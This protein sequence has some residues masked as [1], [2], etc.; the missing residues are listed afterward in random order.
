M[1]L[2]YLDYWY[3]VLVVPAMLISIYAQFKVKST[4]AKYNKIRNVR[5]LTGAA[6]ADMVLKACGIYDVSIVPIQGKLTDNYNPKNKVL[7]LSKD[8]FYGDTIAAVGVACHEAGHAVQHATDYSP[9]KLRSA[10][11]P[12][13]NIGSTIGIPLAI[14]GYI[15]GFSPLISVG[16]AL[17]SLI[18]IFQFV[19][20]PVE[21]NASRRAIQAIEDRGLL[22]DNEID[23]ARKVLKAAAL[24]YVAAL[25]VSIANL[26]R[27]ILRF[28]G[29][30]R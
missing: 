9:I 19:T 17:Y 18:A 29:K 28:S 20:L 15:L 5:G 3:L 7:S 25:I 8:N 14:V 11:V 6:A 22:Y 21:F 10:L 27:F 26:L 16:L 23:S 12:V 1:G 30:R 13:C 4:Y 2:F 24:T